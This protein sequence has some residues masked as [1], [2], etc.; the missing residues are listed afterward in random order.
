MD[1]IRFEPY[2]GSFIFSQDGEIYSVD[3]IP[4]DYC[5][6]YLVNRGSKIVPYNGCSSPIKVQLQYTNR[7]NF[8]CSGCYANSGKPSIDEFTDD[9]IKNLLVGL[10]EFG[11]LQIEWSGGE[12]FTRKNF[13]NMA[14]FAKELGFEQSVLTNGYF[15]DLILKDKSLLWDLFIG[16]QISVNK[17]GQ[18]FDIYSGLKSWRN[19][20]N[21]IDHLCN[22]KPH[23]FRLSITTII[24][25]DVSD[26]YQIANWINGK[27]IVWKLSERVCNGRASSYDNSNNHLYLKESHLKILELKNIFNMKVLHPLDVF[28]ASQDSIFPVEWST[29]MGARWFMYI[30]SN[31]DVYPFPYFDEVSKFLGGNLKN[32]DLEEI[33]YSENFDLY[34]SVSRESTSCKDCNLICPMWAR[35]FNYFKNRDIFETPKC[36]FKN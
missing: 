33:W 28:E 18:K 7:C 4:E 1:L 34:R 22:T 30:K 5:D 10:K 15:I 2:F 12:V 36:N 14:K 26:F 16:V 35:S 32:S 24:D 25:G 17:F 29:E 19:V 11:V 21:T 31:G 20:K 8:N 3:K 13:L 27:D 6:Y 9:E 23:D